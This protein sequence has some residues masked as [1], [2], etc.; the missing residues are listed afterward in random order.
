MK[1]NRLFSGYL[2]RVTL[3]FCLCYSSLQFF[4]EKKKTTTTTTKFDPLISVQLCRPKIL[5]NSWNIFAT[6]CEKRFCLHKT[7]IRTDGETLKNH[8]GKGLFPGEHSLAAGRTEISYGK[9]IW[10]T[11]TTKHL[12]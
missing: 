8:L 1:N 11:P 7:E 10:L 12:P 2:S 6:C 4:R 9:P 5:L 3:V